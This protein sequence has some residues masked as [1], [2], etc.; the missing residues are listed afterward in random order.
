MATTKSPARQETLPDVPQPRQTFAE[1]AAS[2]AIMED[3]PNR[4]LDDIVN[5]DSID[6]ILDGG[7]GNLVHLKDMLTVPF[8]V[9]SVALRESDYQDGAGAFAIIDATLDDDTAV[10]ITTGSSTILAQLIRMVQL[11]AFPI[12][13]RATQSDKATKAGYYPLQLRRPA[14][15]DLDPMSSRAAVLKED[16]F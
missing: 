9:S 5:A 16:G 4:M 3:D 7:S 11:S 6:A 13:V 1:A 8:T 15:A 10:V 14:G 2:I 12:R